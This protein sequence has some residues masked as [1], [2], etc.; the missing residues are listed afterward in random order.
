MSRHGD[1]RPH[2]SLVGR[3]G[4]LNP[5][6]PAARTVVE[7]ADRL[8]P[9]RKFGEQRAYMEFACPDESGRLV[10]LNYVTLAF[11]YLDDTGTDD[12]LVERLV[13]ELRSAYER[14]GRRLYWRL[15]E[16]VQFFT[17]SDNH[18]IIRTRVDILGV[19]WNSV[20]DASNQEEAA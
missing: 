11:A 19:D 10:R 4:H 3:R 20:M 12:G 14:G 5:Q 8:F 17:T 9:S 7:E 15:P 2:G 18:T 13:G 16:M 1:H 6:H